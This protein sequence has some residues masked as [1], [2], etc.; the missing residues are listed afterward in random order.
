MLLNYLR[1]TLRTFFKNKIAF[2]IN[3]IGMSIALGCCITAYV[4]Y[5]YNVAFDKQQK[6]AEN[7]YRIG[8]WQATEKKQVPYGVCPVPAGNLIRESLREG[9]QLIQY[10]S[11]RGQFRIGDEM[12]EREFVYTDQ[13]F[14]NIFS[15]EL[16]SGTF[17]LQDKSK[18]L[19]S[20]KLAFDYFGTQDVVGKPLTQIISGQPLEYEIGGVYKAFATNS[21]FRFDLLAAYDN[22]FTDPT[23][24]SEVENDWSRWSTTFLYLKDESSIAGL[25]KQLQQYVKTQNEARPDLQVQSFYIESFVGMAARATR[26]RNQGHW[27]NQSMPPAAVIAPF[28]MAGFLLLVACFN[29]MNNAIA[30]SGNRLKEIGIRKVIG[31]K[32]KEL[33]LQFLSETMVFCMMSLG[34]ALVLAEYFT[35][36]WNSMWGG[37]EISIQYA[38]NITFLIVLF[39]LMTFTAL[40]AGGYPAFYISAFKPI[41]ILRGT[42]RFGGTN[43]LTKSLLVFQFSISLA[44]V[45][46][47][48]A[49]YSN[50]KF[51]KEYDLGYSWRSVIQVPLENP[52]Q[53]DQLKNE[54]SA[55]PLI[56]SIGGSQH[57]IYSSSYKGAAR[58]EKLKQ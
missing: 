22:Y 21:S 48:L 52:A 56:H 8:F 46:F 31:G 3:L 40:L 55:N 33:I 2:I 11:K 10:I 6:N 4:N 12:F 7:I 43:W 27:F 14:T 20:D 30:V 39:V 19:I 28:V 25:T 26:E 23:Q 41:Q 34:I 29:F 38:D 13:A 54:L 58:N 37:I 1:L 47:A 45:I 18:V 44:A 9:D 49:F 15:M 36:G 50:S 35:D 51:Q 42:T 17:S 53:Y 24:R 16:L 32:R 57:H 5:E